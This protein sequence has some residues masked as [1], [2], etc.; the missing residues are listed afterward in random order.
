MAHITITFSLDPV[1]DA[2]LLEWVYSRRNRSA[3]IRDVLKANLEVDQA[4]RLTLGNLRD[5]LRAELAGLSLVSGVEVSSPEGEEPVEA[6]A[7][8]DNMVERLEEWP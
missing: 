8:L 1:G 3:A 7:N 2:D 6:A 5:A 4:Q